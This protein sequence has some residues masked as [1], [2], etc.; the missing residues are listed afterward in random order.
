M[1]NGSYG[2]VNLVRMKFTK[3]L[4]AM[5]SILKSDSVENTKRLKTEEE[6]YFFIKGTQFVKFYGAFSTENFVHFLLEPIMGGELFY[7]WM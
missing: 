6:I 7:L 1:G 2:E 5:K 4:F 3:K